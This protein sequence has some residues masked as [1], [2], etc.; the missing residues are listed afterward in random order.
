MLQDLHTKCKDVRDKR[1]LSKLYQKIERFASAW[2]PFFEVTSIFV[3]AHSEF[4]GIAWGAICLMFLLGTN[5]T[6]HL[7]KLVTQRRGTCAVWVA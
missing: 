4:A 7:E 6:V 1:K 2:E 5:Y 3:Q